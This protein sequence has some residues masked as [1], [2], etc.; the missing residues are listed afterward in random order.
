MSHIA[1]RTA[2]YTFHPTAAGLESQEL[3]VRMSLVAFLQAAMMVA[4]WSARLICCASRE[5]RNSANPFSRTIPGSYLHHC[6]GVT[7][8]IDALFISLTASS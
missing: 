3:T 6:H 5:L 1:K 2:V 4:C 7:A 8:A